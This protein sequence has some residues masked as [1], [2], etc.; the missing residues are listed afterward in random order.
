MC[1]GDM[2]KIDIF[3][4]NSIWTKRIDE[5]T[6]EKLTIVLILAL[7][8]F[9]AIVVIYCFSI[10]RKYNI[11]VGLYNDLLGKCICPGG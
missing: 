11:L 6:K 3:E 2:M 8:I 5:T 7:I 1:G 4:K 9:A 10:E